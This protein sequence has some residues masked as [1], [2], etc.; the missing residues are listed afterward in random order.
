[1]TKSKNF[2]IGIIISISFLGLIALCYLL[3]AYSIN[4]WPFVSKPT[5]KSNSIGQL[6]FLK[7]D[8]KPGETCNDD[9]KAGTSNGWHISCDSKECNDGIRYCINGKNEIPGWPAGTNLLLTPSGFHGKYKAS[10]W[11]KT[12]S[13]KIK[14]Y[15][16]ITGIKLKLKAPQSGLKYEVTYINLQE[17]SAT[18]SGSLNIEPNSNKPDGTTGDDASTQR[19]YFGNYDDSEKRDSEKLSIKPVSR[20]LDDANN[21]LVIGLKVTDSKGNYFVGDFNISDLSLNCKWDKA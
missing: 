3:L 17:D 12:I 5:S 10:E 6:S 21:H 1:M 18:N 11:G 16:Y 8:N 2:S 15:T 9:N 4:I 7:G 20:S 19:I 13:V 14:D